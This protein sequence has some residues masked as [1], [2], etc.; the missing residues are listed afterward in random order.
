[1]KHTLALLCPLF[2]LTVLPL[3]AR[4]NPGALEINQDC[5]TVGCFAG[6]T[7]GYPVSISQPGS[8]VL[9]ADLLDSGSANAIE[10]FASPVD[11]DLN[12]HTIDG[13]NSCTGSPVTTC[14]ALGSG[15]GFNVTTSGRAVVRIHNGTVRGFG[16]G[17]IV[18]F[19]ADDGTVLEHLTLTENA[20]GALIV[21]YSTTS[22][23]R[24]RDS[25]AVRNQ[26][27]GI[28]IAN[29]SS[30]IQAENNTIV[31]NGS[32][33]LLVGSGSTVVGNRFSNNSNVGLSCSP[34]T[35]ALGQNTFVGNNSAG[36]QYTVGTVS[37]MSGNVCLDHVGSACP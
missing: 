21:G 5:A 29:G 34:G 6:D 14:T 12:G 18:I 37:N 13:G 8:Y 27:D 1:M 16:G 26:N 25:Q 17:G 33:G 9:T 24:V 23:T 2:A 3:A 31:G 19:S 32:V 28:T 10:I 20:Y 36:I 11:I 7:A 15:R 35:C 4:A 22:T 30:L